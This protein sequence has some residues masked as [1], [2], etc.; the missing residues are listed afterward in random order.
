MGRTTFFDH[1]RITFRHGR[2]QTGELL[3]SSRCR[4]ARHLSARRK[5]VLYLADGVIF[6][7][8]SSGQGK[9]NNLKAAAEFISWLRSDGIRPSRFPIVYLYHKD[10][11]KNRS[12]LRIFKKLF[13]LSRAPMING[14]AYEGRGIW[15]ALN[16]AVKIILSSKGKRAIEDVC[17]A[18]RRP[19]HHE[20]IRGYL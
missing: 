14:S 13:S 20:G 2:R 9:V 10:D 1:L 4:E 11:L 17:L 15:E 3:I 7:L 6:T 12:S 19:G 18:G 5:K 16:T 8:D